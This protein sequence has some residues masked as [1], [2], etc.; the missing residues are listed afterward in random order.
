MHNL[1]LLTMPQDKRTRSDGAAELSLKLLPVV[2]G[3][4]HARSSNPRATAC[5]PRTGSTRRNHYDVFALIWLRLCRSPGRPILA[6]GEQVKL[7]KHRNVVEQRSIREA[8]VGNPQLRRDTPL[9][10]DV[11]PAV[12]ADRTT[13][14][15]ARDGYQPPMSAEGKR[16]GS[17][18]AWHVTATGRSPAL[19]TSA[20]M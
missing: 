20:V 11:N 16:S 13:A 14:R 17:W 15:A 3:I 2:R 7:V 6:P 1:R 8:S 10:C 9:T 12:Q 18:P 4:A 5:S 19:R